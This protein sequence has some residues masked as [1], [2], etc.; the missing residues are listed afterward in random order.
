MTNRVRFSIDK[1]KTVDTEL[2]DVVIPQIKSHVFL[3]DEEFI[4]KNITYGYGAYKYG[5]ILIDVALEHMEDD[6]YADFN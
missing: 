2:Q 4:V 3:H 5:Y 6:D 1:E